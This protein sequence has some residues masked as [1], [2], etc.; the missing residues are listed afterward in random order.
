MMWGGKARS[1]NHSTSDFHRMGERRGRGW[2]GEGKFKELLPCVGGG[3]WGNTTEERTESP[4]QGSLKKR[5]DYSPEEREYGA[6]RWGFRDRSIFE[7][8]RYS[9]GGHV[10]DCQGSIILLPLGTSSCLVLVGTRGRGLS[11]GIRSLNGGGGGA[12]GCL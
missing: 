12:T 2:G 10:S 5:D 1:L 7:L 4:C 8:P 3:E 6:P 9:L 11:P